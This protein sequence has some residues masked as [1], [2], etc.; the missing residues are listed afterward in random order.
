MTNPGRVGGRTDDRIDRRPPT[1]PH[2][3]F[4]DQTRDWPAGAPACSSAAS[5]RLLVELR[6]VAKAI[7]CGGGIAAWTIVGPEASRRGE[8]GWDSMLDNQRFRE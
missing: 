6:L 2:E 4:G 8:P 5:T 3:R 1:R 7:A